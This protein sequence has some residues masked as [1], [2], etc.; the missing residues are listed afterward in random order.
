MTTYFRNLKDN[1]VFDTER[2]EYYENDANYKRVTAKEGK[3]AVMEQ[4]RQYL[5]GILMPG[6]IVYTLIR[7][8]SASG[9]RREVAV[10]VVNEGRIRDITNPAAFA[11]DGTIGKHRG[12]IVNGCGFDAGFDLVYRLGKALGPEGTPKPHGTRNGEPDSD[13]GY[14]LKHEWI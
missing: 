6:D 12:I 4:E 13:G 8:V 14:A 10:F 7:H 2:P 1:T 11:V 9:M 3:A 5:R